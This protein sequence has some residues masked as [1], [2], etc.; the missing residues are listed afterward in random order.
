MLID[1]LSERLKKSREVSNLISELN[2]C[3]NPVFAAPPSSRSLL[4]ASLFRQ[5]PRPMLVVMAGEDA[6]RRFALG[7]SFYLGQDVV[8]HF[9]FDSKK[10]WSKT[11]SDPV[12]VGKRLR[13]LSALSNGEHV[14]VVACVRS[15]MTLYPP[16]E[17]MLLTPLAFTKGRQL[18][19]LEYED[20]SEKLTSLG[21]ARQELATEHATYAIHGDVVDIYG[22]DS[23]CPY[24]IEFFGD[25]I[26]RIRKIVLST[27][28][29]I[30]DLDSVTIYPA[31]ESIVDKSDIKRAK[32]KL[33]S[34]G[35]LTYEI[36]A[37]LNAILDFGIHG[38]QMQYAPFLFEH[39]SAPMEFMN[40]DVLTILVEPRSLFGDS[41]RYRE[42]LESQASEV[43]AS[44][45]GLYL[46][47]S[48]MRFDTTQTL[49]ILSLMKQGAFLSGS[50]D[51]KRADN[52]INPERM[53]AQVRGLLAKKTM[54]VMGIADRRIRQEAMLELTEG[55]IP[56]KLLVDDDELE[57]DIVNISEDPISIPLIIPSAHL[58]ILGG[59]DELTGI[60]ESPG[61]QVGRQTQFSLPFKPGDYVV[62][63]KYGVALFADITRQEVDG[64]WRDYLI[65][66][67][68]AGDKLFIPVEQIGKITKYV[69]AKGVEPKLTRLN[70]NDWSHARRKASK[71][72]KKLAF[73]LVDL[74]V[75]RSS[76]KGH[77]YPKDTEMQLQMESMFPY[78]ETSDQAKAI[79]DVK[80]DMESSR[81]MDRLICG[82]VGFGKTEVAIRAAFKAVQDGM[83]VMVLCPTTILAQQ[84][85]TT[86][87]KRFEPF[88]VTVEIL[89]RF[90]TPPQ[91]RKALEGF[92]EGKVDVLV[93]THRL[94]S[95]DVSPKSLGLVIIDEEQRFGVRHKEQLKNLREQIDVLALTATPIPRTLQ[96]S[97]GGVRDMSV[98]NT[99]PLH[100]IPV[101][102]YVGEWDSDLISGAIRREIERGG[103]VYYVSTRIANM[104]DAITAITEAV[105]EARVG[106]A[107]GKMG[108]TALEK[109]MESFAAGEI[110][111]LV[112]TTIVESGIDNPRTNTLIIDDSHM[113]GLSQLYQ[114]K[115][116][117]G[118]SHVQAYAYFMFPKDIP[119]TQEAVERLVAIK[120]NQELGSGI[121]IAMRDLEIRGAGSLLGA[122][123]SGNISAIGFEAFM[124]LL[125][126]YVDE[127][128]G[129]QTSH[130]I[131]DTV[132]DVPVEI[133]L[134]EDYVELTEER[135]AI[136][137]D[138]AMARDKDEIQKIAINLENE[139]GP[140][141]FEAQNLIDRALLQADIVTIGAERLV[142]NDSKITI[143]PVKLDTRQ[144][145]AAKK[146]GATYFTKTHKLTLRV[147]E[148]SSPLSYTLE[149]LESIIN[150]KGEA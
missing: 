78:E 104:E 7:L 107:H 99:A 51:A 120:E 101:E 13:A 58:A 145:V 91:Q 141:P 23:P 33:A 137:R 79:A 92:S 146:A 118:R 64:L 19:E 121:K 81:P 105:P 90:R 12:I 35:L 80:A 72:A 103:Q 28:Q 132:V 97:L 30:S 22:A 76:V 116:R 84:H 6:A 29:T 59:G 95:R 36:E 9:P 17:R 54:V 69:G 134:P 20:V 112:S 8:L 126:E 46:S 67:Y 77:A 83:Q 113:L 53:V 60:A 45:E 117:V 109:V 65:L 37:D 27:G 61:G 4:I 39:M 128:R 114:L 144:A 98:I 122:E 106:F 89:S 10:P 57:E 135:V 111:V 115:G 119:L 70:T 129:T 96:M 25:E 49:S 14:I 73:D 102:V 68:A 16:K 147:P 88:P 143:D 110:D 5:K 40:K 85:Y 148:S 62:H 44:L 74:Y 133:Y 1:L 82:D 86:F 47:P 108:E 55:H 127:A 21:Y 63:L 87:S 42:E 24:R 32:A 123:Q 100:R 94:L 41:T 130:S 48:N 31:R 66:E 140:L 138:I 11:E 71:D 38:S 124:S 142:L 75:R 93:G 50:L 2:C 18:D 136:Y 125:S 139:Y 52:P 15:L 150:A 34:A 43:K 149:C 26:D 3:E 131:S 56:I